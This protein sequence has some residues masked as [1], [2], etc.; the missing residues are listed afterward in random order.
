MAS[1]QHFLGLVDARR[2]TRRPPVVGM[3]FL[4][5]RAM[6]SRNILAGSAFRKPQDLIGFILGHFSRRA[7]AGLVSAPRVA[8][9][10]VCRAP[11]GKAAVQI[12]F[13]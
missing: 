1:H 12:S 10:I 6:G 11:S 3:K 7:R 9:R 5:E 4:H 2:E 8:T 13:Q